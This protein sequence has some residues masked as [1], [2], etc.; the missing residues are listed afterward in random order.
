MTSVVAIRAYEDRDHDGVLAVLR[1]LQRWEYQLA[2]RIKAPE[3]L[4]PDYIAAMLND[5]AKHRGVVL[6]AEHGTE[7]VGYCSLL[8]HCDSSEDIDEIF[9][10]YA[11]IND[12]GVAANMR[13]RGIGA[14]LVSA[15][16]DIA[17][18]EGLSWLRLSVL[19]ANGA[20]RRFYERQGFGEN[21]ILLEKQ[22]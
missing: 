21:L 14:K 4:G 20:A 10:T 3:D 1:D 19:A 16:E 18:R 11:Y 15:A 17:R 6:V 9:Y 22:L 8:T 13:S 12:L 2:T 5:V 7:I